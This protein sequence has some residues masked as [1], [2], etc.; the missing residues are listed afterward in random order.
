MAFT[1]HYAPD[2]GAENDDHRF[3]SVH[4]AVV[5]DFFGIDGKAGGF[6]IALQKGFAFD[7]AADDEPVLRVA[8]AVPFLQGPSEI[9]MIVAQVRQLPV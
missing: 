1:A 5:S 4:H 9:L 2:A 6:G 3:P 7:Q 8:I